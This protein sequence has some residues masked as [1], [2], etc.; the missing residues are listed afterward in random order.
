MKIRLVHNQDGQPTVDWIGVCLSWLIIAAIGAAM[1]ALIDWM[2]GWGFSAFAY[3]WM[4]VVFPALTLGG[5]VWRGL[6]LPVDDL[7][8]HRVA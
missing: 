8:Q 6:K 7:A 1:V 5:S 2:L 3:A 4:L